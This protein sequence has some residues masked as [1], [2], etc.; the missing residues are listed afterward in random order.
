VAAARARALARGDVAALNRAA[1]LRA[2]MPSATAV[3]GALRAPFILVRF[4]NTDTTTLRT[5]ASYDSVLI[6]TT[7]PPGRPFTLRTFFG[8]LSNGMFSVQGQ[9]LGW[10][11]LSE[12][13]VYYAGPCNGLCGSGQMGSLMTEAFNALDASVDF[14]Q[15]DNDGPDDIPNSGDDDGVVDLVAF[16]HPEQDGA[17]TSGSNG[18]IWSHRFLYSEWTGAQYQTNDPRAG[19][20]FIR[21]DD[22]TIQSAVG[23]NTSCDASSMM[24]IGTIAHE[25]GHGLDVPDL[26]DT[27][28]YDEDDS[29]GIGNWGLMGAGNIY[30]SPLSPSPMEAWSRARLGW[31][32]VR[33]LTAGGSYTLGPSASRDTALL[34]RP[35]VANLRNE[36]FLLE[37]RQAV[38]SDTAMVRS[39]G[40]G[41]LVWHVDS[42]QIA[43]GSLNDNNV[44]NTG[45][46]HGVWLRQAD[47]LNQLRSSVSGFRNR[48]DAGD[49]YPGAAMNTRFFD[50]N[51]A[52]TLNT[53]IFAGFTLD[54]IRQ[55]EP[56][57]AMAFRLDFG[58]SVAA[59][60]PA[61]AGAPYSDTLRLAG[62]TRTYSFS[63]LAGQ[64]PNGLSLSAAGVISGIPWRDSTWTA[65]IR[66]TGGSIVIDFPISLTVG[67][68]Q[69]ALDAVAEH[70]LTGNGSLTEDERRYLDLI[71]NRNERV[72][73]GD[74]VAWLDRTGTAVDA[75]TLARVMRGGRR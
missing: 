49:P 59:L 54:S 47:G 71:G 26:Y 68:P 39:L 28:P 63:L 32:T 58:V 12:T 34:I 53:G 45:N 75:A 31:I 46:I 29:E 65:T 70:L 72:D 16:I 62:S 35:T 10:V 37:N 25:F 30:V 23:G 17:C 61:L 60:S 11:A 55:V 67:A 48:G 38:G 15:F 19:G 2:P 36:Y 52:A 4:S 69:L 21:I 40:P 18:N 51:P 56:D 22:Y 7:P 3:T 24:A 64:L 27:N 57:G 74:F 42:A 20:G 6:A 14:G 43:A 5:A 1:G 13:D 8:D 9:V 73:V 50:G 44:V 41:L 33:P 66:A